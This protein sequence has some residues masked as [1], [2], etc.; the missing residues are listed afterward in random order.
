MPPLNVSLDVSL[1]F[2]IDLNAEYTKQGLTIYVVCSR[3]LGSWVGL[4][5]PFKI[6]VLLKHVFYITIVIMH[7]MQTQL[8]TFQNHL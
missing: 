7:N 1:E 2:S 3:S 5:K 4:K 6:K 8:L